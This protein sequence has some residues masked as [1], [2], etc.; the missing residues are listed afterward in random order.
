MQVKAS[1]CREEATC[2]HD[3]ETLPS[4]SY[5]TGNLH[6]WKGSIVFFREGLAYFIKTMLNV[7][8]PEAATKILY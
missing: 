2:E 3:P 8:D 6:I 4:S 5:G 1:S 7:K